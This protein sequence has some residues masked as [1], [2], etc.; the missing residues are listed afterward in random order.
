MVTNQDF[1]HGY[2]IDWWESCLKILIIFR[3]LLNQIDQ[4]NRITL[5]FSAMRRL[6]VYIWTAPSLLGSRIIG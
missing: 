3:L 6:S 5:R 2:G 4:M 1:C